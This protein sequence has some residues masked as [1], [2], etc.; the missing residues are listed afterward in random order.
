MKWEP[1]ELGFPKDGRETLVSDIS[2]PEI[3]SAGC[4]KDATLCSYSISNVF[5]FE[6]APS[7]LDEILLRPSILPSSLGSALCLAE[8]QP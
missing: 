1:S 8:L 2:L 5:P 4:D 3:W 6:D 7:E